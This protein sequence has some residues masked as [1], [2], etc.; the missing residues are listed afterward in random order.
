MEVRMPKTLVI[1]EKPS[2]GSDIAKVLGCRDR[3][4]GY[5]E[6]GDYVVTW[7]IGHL[8][9]LCSPEEMDGRLKAWSFDTLPMLPDEMKLKVVGRTRDQYGVI[10]RLMSQNDVS[11]II[12]AT[13][14]GREGELIFRYIYKVAGCQKPFSRL[15]ISSMTDEAIREGFG[16]LKPGK[17]YDNLYQ[18]ARCRA[19]ADWLVGMNGSRGFTLQY[20]RLLSVGRVQSP[21]LAIMVNREREI[22]SFVPE[23]YHELWAMFSGFK[24]R[25]FD[26]ADDS[27]GGRIPQ[28]K[29]EWAG[30]F[31]EELKGKPYKVE[32]SSGS[33]DL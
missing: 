18:S 5:V 25:W 8:V 33:K 20:D 30:K 31:A 19:E 9:T 21:T 14:S 1:A 24:G 11:D 13:D 7:A 3:R 27:R 12:C 17:E 29:L 15:W 4:K 23:K 6:G 32:R 28:D 22:Q 26:E 16:R 2:V 10:K